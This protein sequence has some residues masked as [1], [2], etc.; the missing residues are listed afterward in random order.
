MT[1]NDVKSGDRVLVTINKIFAPVE[2]IVGKA[3]V[4]QTTQAWSVGKR[5][6]FTQ[7]KGVVLG[8]GTL[9]EGP[10]LIVQFVAIPNSNRTGVVH[11]NYFA[12]NSLWVYE[13]ETNINTVVPKE[14]SDKRNEWPYTAYQLP[15]SNIYRKKVRLIW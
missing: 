14:I 1:I 15:P 13:G 5:S 10:T 11:I 12:I 6:T 3:P 2:K 9:Y 7:C 4:Y 8:R